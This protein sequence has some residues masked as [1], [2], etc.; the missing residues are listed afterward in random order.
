MNYFLLQLKRKLFRT[1][2]LLRILCKACAW[3]N[4]FFP[5]PNYK[6][7]HEAEGRQIEYKIRF[8]LYNHVN[9]FLKQYS[10]FQKIHHP[11]T[12]WHR[13]LKTMYLLVLRHWRSRKNTILTLKI[14]YYALTLI[15]CFSKFFHIIVLSV[16]IPF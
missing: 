15:L 2:G 6:Y 12:V 11:L 14:F 9:G 5:L 1:R 16:S 8:Q 13:F 3:N 4:Q 7:K 10:K